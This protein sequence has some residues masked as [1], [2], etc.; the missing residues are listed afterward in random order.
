[1]GS[2]RVQIR[3]FRN[4]HELDAGLYAHT[5]IIRENRIGKSN[6]ICALRRLLDPTM[7]D[8]ARQLRREDFWAAEGWLIQTA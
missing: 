4:F 3:N 7:P 1:M 5:V 8:S 2:G 6:F